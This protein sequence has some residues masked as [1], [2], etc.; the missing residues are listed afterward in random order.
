MTRALLLSLCLAP[1]V[2]SASKPEFEPFLIESHVT[3]MRDGVRLATDIY[4]PGKDGKPVEGKYPAIVYRT[5]YNKTGLKGMGA[6]LASRGYAVVAQDVRGRFKSEGNFYAFVNEGPDGHDTIEWAASQAWSNGKVGTAG[7]S[8]LA[9]DQYLGAMERPPHLTAMYADV[10]GNT[11]YDEF[12]WPGGAPNPAWGIWI[13]NSAA[14]SPQAAADPAARVALGEAQKNA[15]AW[16]GQPPSARAE[17]FA[18]SAIG[19]V[20]TG[21]S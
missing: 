4:L 2:Y 1:A 10:G 5:P 3:A 11:F 14:S 8:Y 19:P 9:W 13:L 12:A 20:R 17:V 21:C 15:M 7:A 16:L 18:P 6:Y